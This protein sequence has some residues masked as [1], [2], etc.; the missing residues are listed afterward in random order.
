VSDE[1]A[2]RDP[3]R[4]L[5]GIFAGVL[6]M[7]AVVVGLALLVVGRLGGGLA[8]WYTG[9]LALAMVVA[10]GVQRRSWGLGVA[11]MLQVAMVAGW[12]AHP[13]LGGLGLLFVLVWG[14][15]LYV[16]RVVAGQAGRSSNGK[17][18]HR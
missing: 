12:F 6:V 18:R 10:A 3:L 11:L 15:L 9:G 4:G 13:V 14:Y 2:Q 7:E 8:G 16:R 17:D 1:L 5:R